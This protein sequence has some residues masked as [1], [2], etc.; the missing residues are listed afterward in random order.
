LPTVDRPA[1]DIPVTISSSCC[2]SRCVIGTF[3]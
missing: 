3:R 1:P 2:S